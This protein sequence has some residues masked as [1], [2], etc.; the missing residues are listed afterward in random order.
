MQPAVSALIVDGRMITSDPEANA[1]L[2]PAAMPE[3]TLIVCVWQ[4]GDCQ[5]VT[6]LDPFALRAGALQTLTSK[7][8]VGDTPPTLRALPDLIDSLYKH[9]RSGFQAFEHT[10]AAHLPVLIASKP[11]VRLIDGSSLA[12]AVPGQACLRPRGQGEGG[13]YIGVQSPPLETA[14]VELG[15]ALDG[16]VSWPRQ[17][18]QV[19]AQMFGFP[20]SRVVYHGQVGLGCPPGAAVDLR[21]LPS[22]ERECQLVVMNGQA[23][24][25]TA[26]AV[27][28]PPAPVLVARPVT[29]TVPFVPGATVRVAIP[30]DSNASGASVRI[31]DSPREGTLQPPVGNDV[32][33]VI[34]QRFVAEDRFTFALVDMRGL[35]SAPAE[36]RISFTHSRPVAADQAVSVSYNGGRVVKL[37]PAN[38]HDVQDAQVVVMDDSHGL[39]K[40]I[41]GTDVTVTPPGGSLAPSSFRYVLEANGV[42]SDPATVTVTPELTV[43]LQPQTVSVAAGAESKPI[44][45]VTGRGVPRDLLPGHL[46]LVV[47]PAQPGGAAIGRVDPDGKSIVVTG[48]PAAA[49][50]VVLPFRLMSDEL[51]RAIAEAAIDVTVTLPE[52]RTACGT[53]D[54]VKGGMFYVPRGILRIPAEEK[55]FFDRFGDLLPKMEVTV[56]TPFCMAEQETRAAD[57]TPDGD[58]QEYKPLLNSEVASHMT[59]TFA[60][61][62]ARSLDAQSPGSVHRLPTRQQWLAAFIVVLTDPKLKKNAALVDSFRRG[63]VRN[64]TRDPCHQEETD[65]PSQY[66]AIG[67]Y[68][69]GSDGATLGD[70]SPLECRIGSMMHM[71]IGFRVVKEL[72]KSSSP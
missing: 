3:H 6:K 71:D 8:V 70:Y 34:G 61:D 10:G 64:W 27:P 9:A 68:T 38:G 29:L 37:G 32:T 56:E 41:D 18:E 14:K 23:A 16:A 54:E 55:D 7:R 42:R 33:Y 49:S 63:E 19:L 24:P 62:Y 28:A 66:W 12:R 69:V 2:L 44:D 65:I 4:Q 50:K 47:D 72:P 13:Q 20:D 36:V 30:A 31:V 45:V 35:A 60:A 57:L 67:Y 39:I 43:R 58:E 25:P 5:E 1:R 11:D 15:I 52:S 53:T 51:N 26:C 40:R 22:L 46:H 59:Q 17:A 48:G 21:P